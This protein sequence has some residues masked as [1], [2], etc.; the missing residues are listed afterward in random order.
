MTAGFTFRVQNFRGLERFEWSP[1]GVVLLTG[2]NGAGKTTAL[3]ALR[4]VRDLWTRGLQDALRWAG[5][6]NGLRSRGAGIDAPVTLELERDGA[7]W[8]VRLPFAGG[9]FAGTLRTPYLGETL[10]HDGADALRVPESAASYEL[11]GVVRGRAETTSE[12]EVLFTLTQQPWLGDLRAFVRGIR[13]YDTWEL[14]N[15]A[16]PVTA[17]ASDAQL[18]A[19]G[20]NLVFVLRN[21]KSAPRRFADQYAWVV[22][23]ARKA[24]P[25]VFVDLEF[26]EG[27]RTEFVPVDSTAAD[28]TLPLH[29]APDGLLTG[30]LV[31]TAVAGAQRGSVLAFDEIE[32]QLHPH[33]IRSLLASLRSRAAAQDL[34]VIL[35]TH[36]PVVMNAF[37][38]E[39]EQVFVLD[40]ES[41]TL[42][43]AMSEL[44]EEAW[45]AQTKLGTLYEQMAFAA[46]FLG[47]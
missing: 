31:L 32:N 25:D 1:E 30:L 27:G 47:K 23:E 46:P 41:P 4:F 40:R 2:A 37:R 14:R 38:S 35:T 12:A 6:V 29:L 8:T 28:D 19:S 11:D 34:T 7:V 26:H 45:L 17:D 39:P 16:R 18:D 20:K 22:A 15:L 44:H 10:R 21:W 36:S 43:V 24:F 3:T 42:P 13:V 33:A 5:G 9:G